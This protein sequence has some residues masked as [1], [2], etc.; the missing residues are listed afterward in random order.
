MNMVKQRNPDEV[1]EEYQ[2]F[3]G[4]R[5]RK[6]RSIVPDNYTPDELSALRHILLDRHHDVRFIPKT[7]DYQ[8]AQKWLAKHHMDERYYAVN[9]DLDQDGIPDVEIREKGSDRPVVFKGYTV[10]KSRAPQRTMLAATYPDWDERKKHNFADALDEQTGTTYRSP[11]E[12]TMMNEDRV[13]YIEQ[14]RSQGYRIRA[15]K[16]KIS[17][18]S[19]FK[20]FI[21]KPIMR[22]IKAT[23]KDA[24]VRIKWAAADAV[25]LEKVLRVNVVTDVAMRAVYGDEAVNNMDPPTYEDMR[26]VNKVPEYEMFTLDTLVK[27]RRQIAGIVA[28]WILEYLMMENFLPVGDYDIGAIVETAV[29]FMNRQRMSAEDGY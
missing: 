1:S 15:P 17:V 22:A 21:M 24:N 9:Q 2:R 25:K 7:E 10:A 27:N 8:D 18:A 29:D 23:L 13:N 19:A 14:L 11:F 16:K 12:R 20:Y 26:K 4:G 6:A 28:H 3:S 5:E